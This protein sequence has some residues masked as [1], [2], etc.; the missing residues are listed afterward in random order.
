MSD[1]PTSLTFPLAII[2]GG[3]TLP[4][5]LAQA[6]QGK[7]VILSYPGCGS[8]VHQF[9]HISLTLAQVEQAVLYVQKC[10]VKDIVCAGSFVRPRLKDLWPDALGRQLLKRIGL[11]WSG[12]D[13][14][15]RIVA[16]FVQ[17]CGLKLW[18]PQDILPLLACNSGALTTRH[19]CEEALQDIQRGKQI[20]HTLSPLDFGQGLA[21]QEGLVLGIEAAE[22]TDACIARCGNLQK[23]GKH[24]AIYVKRT[25][26]G[27]H[28][29]MDWPGIGPQTITQ[30]FLAGFQG[31][32]FEAHRTL[33]MQKEEAIEKANLYNLFLWGD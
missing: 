13:A 20:L 24:K 19:P 4:Q 16:D 23:E 33:I 22:G 14:V 2:A 6:W 17:D 11:R 3:G 26:V 28:Q 21:I 27:Q 10:G 30:L 9:Q 29:A 12:D 32:A 7:V 31:L 18:S 8:W 5:M 25:K 1:L 15:L